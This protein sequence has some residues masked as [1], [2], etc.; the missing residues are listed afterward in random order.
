ME[1]WE[2]GRPWVWERFETAGIVVSWVLIGVKYSPERCAAHAAT[3]NRG[4]FST[5][6]ATPSPGWR[7]AA[8]H[9]RASR[10]DCASSSA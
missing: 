2:L 8:R 3:R 10:A 1:W 5:S 9:A 6:R 7:P 4:W